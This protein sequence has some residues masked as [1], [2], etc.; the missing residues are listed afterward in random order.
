M[1]V[2]IPVVE[3]KDQLFPINEA[4]ILG[5]SMT[6]LAAKEPLV[7]AGTRFDVSNSD[8]WLWLHQ[9]LFHSSFSK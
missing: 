9:M 1:F 7:P 6:T 5:V 3:L 8:Q 2:C 4:P